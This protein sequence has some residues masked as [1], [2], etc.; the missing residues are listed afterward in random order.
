[1]SVLAR[2]PKSS[3]GFWRSFV[4][5]EAKNRELRESGSMAQPSTTSGTLSLVRGPDLL[6]RKSQSGVPIGPRSGRPPQSV[7]IHPSVGSTAMSGSQDGSSLR[8]DPL[9]R[10]GATV[11]PGL[12]LGGGRG[13]QALAA[14]RSRGS[15]ATARTVARVKTH[16]ANSRRARIQVGAIEPIAFTASS[17]RTPRISRL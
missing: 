1:M 13:A 12:A 4:E 15:T 8:S 14:G 6:I 9:I 17:S 2:I 3:F 5:S 10:K 7:D 11:C 16:S